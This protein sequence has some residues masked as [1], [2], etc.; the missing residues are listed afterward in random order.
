[1]YLIDVNLSLALAFESHIHHATSILHP[2]PSTLSLRPNRGGVAVHSFNRGDDFLK[3]ALAAQQDGMMQR[4]HLFVDARGV[5]Q[6]IGGPKS[7]CRM[8]FVKRAK[9]RVERDSLGPHGEGEVVA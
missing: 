9:S 3:I 7:A 1:M 6:W 8:R 5:L 4:E 2:L